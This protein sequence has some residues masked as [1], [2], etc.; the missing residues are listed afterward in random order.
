MCKAEAR[1]TEITRD[2]ERP[3][4][5]NVVA[6]VEV[7]DTE[8]NR[9]TPYQTQSRFMT[10]T[11]RIQEEQDGDS[12]DRYCRSWELYNLIFQIHLSPKSRVKTSFFL[13]MCLLVSVS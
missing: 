4:E 1:Q 3:R 9:D 2:G 6:L 8:W 11:L 5:D 7:D 12:L 10:H 13:N